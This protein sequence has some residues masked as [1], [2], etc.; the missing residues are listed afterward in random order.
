[1]AANAR[2]CLAG[3]VVPFAVSS[4]K[5]CREAMVESGP[6]PAARLGGPKTL[7]TI[8]VALVLLGPS[9]SAVVVGPGVARGIVACPFVATTVAKVRKSGSGGAA[10]YVSLV[11]ISKSRTQETEQKGLAASAILAIVAMAF[12]ATTCQMASSIGL[13]A[14]SPLAVRGPSMGLA[15]VDQGRRATSGVSIGPSASR[16]PAIASVAACQE[17]VLASGQQVAIVV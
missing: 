13:L 9:P 12:L 4:Q 17:S 3:L 16:R 11:A 1:M 15:I 10:L 2:S 5:T 6:S 14:L 8:I 7:T